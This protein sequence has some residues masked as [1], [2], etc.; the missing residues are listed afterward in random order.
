M[1]I[2]TK[3]GD[4]GQ[5]SLFSGDR[6]YKDDLRVEAYG[7]SDELISFIAELKFFVDEKIKSELEKIQKVLFKINA[8]LAGGKDFKLRETDISFVEKSLESFE[9]EY[10]KIKEF[11]IPS[12]TLVAA[13]CDIC[14]TVC[15]R[16]ERRVV[17]LAKMVDID[18]NVLKFI[19]RLSDY[20]F[21]LA[22]VLAKREGGKR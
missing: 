11:I 10:G 16:F 6:V 20:F 22:R 17:S 19:N 1:S 4:T 3:K 2:S 8:Y 14:R 18:N 5:T 13:K 21:M 7:T 12:E 15:R 9:E